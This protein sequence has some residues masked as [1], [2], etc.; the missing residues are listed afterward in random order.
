MLSNRK[1][2]QISAVVKIVYTELLLRW[3]FGVVEL[4]DSLIAPLWTYV[5]ADRS[6]YDCWLEAN[7]LPF[8]YRISEQPNPSLP[9]IYGISE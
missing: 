5:I 8:I 1:E 7:E 2:M 9:F 4:C 6:P 3:S